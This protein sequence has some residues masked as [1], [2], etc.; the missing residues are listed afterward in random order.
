MVALSFVVGVSF[1]QQVTTIAGSGVVGST[2]GAG[3]GASFSSPFGVATDEIGNL[4]VADAANNEIR[5]I[6]IATG[7]VSTLAGS[8]TTGNADGFGAAASFNSPS[9]ITTDG[10][11]NLYVADKL[12]NEI[13]KVVIATGEVSTIAGTI[14]SGSAD[15]KITA[16]SFYNPDG[17]VYDGSGNLY[18]ADGLNHEIRKIVISTGVVSTIAGSTTSGFING[19]GTAARFNTPVGLA[20]D[21]NGDL[22]VADMGNNEIREIVLST[23][24]VS[25]L[26]GCTSWGSLDGMGASAKFNAPYGVVADGSGNLFIADYDNN[27]IRKIVIASG[28]VTTIAGSTKCGSANGM[29]SS[30]GFKSVAG[31]VAD[32]NG[33]LY[34]ADMGNH[35]IRKIAT[36]FTGVNNITTST[37]LSV[38]PNPA[39]QVIH[40]DLANEGGFVPTVIN[41]ID[42]SGKE[43]IVNKEAS[44]SDKTIS[45]DISNL[46]RGMYFV[47]VVMNDNSSKVE[48]FIKE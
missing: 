27:E 11:G 42:M 25:T 41:V 37:S 7:E 1:A 29:G 12:N 19:K 2:D 34:V 13:R 16:A 6:D 22:F 33:N 30:A 3:A 43:V 4:Y 18:I 32:G 31:I 46:A 21:A 47:Q 28:M 5:K 23:A 26:A 45:I 14:A 10:N 24:N 39:D 35:E 40:L 36:L 15:G 9:G 44:I 17:L 38:Y 8:G 48:K 20:I